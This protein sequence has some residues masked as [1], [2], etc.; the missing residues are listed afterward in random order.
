MRQSIKEPSEAVGLTLAWS[1]RQLGE[2]LMKMR[3]CQQEGVIVPRLKL[4]RIELNSIVSPASKF[5]SLENVDGLAVATFVFLLTEMVEKVEELAKEV[6]E[7]GD[8]AGFNTK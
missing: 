4:M 8:L 5:E 1:L 2:S 7:L 6:E 3:G